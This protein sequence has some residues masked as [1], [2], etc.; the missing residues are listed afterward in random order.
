VD[1]SDLTPIANRKL[2]YTLDRIQGTTVTDDRGRG[3]IRVISTSSL[4]RTHLKLSTGV[5]FLML[6]AN[7]ITEIATPP[8]WC[9]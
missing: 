6:R 2:T 8:D 5:D 1:R 7:E 9:R 4:K 3:T